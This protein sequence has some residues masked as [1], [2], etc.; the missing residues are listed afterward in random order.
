MFSFQ[1]ISIAIFLILIS[2]ILLIGV[3]GF[4]VVHEIYLLIETSNNGLQLIADVR[5][6]QANTYSLLITE[7]LD[8]GY[9]LWGECVQKYQQNLDRF[10]NS[11]RLQ[12]LLQD[13]SILINYKAFQILSR[14]ALESITNIEKEYREIRKQLPYGFG[15]LFLEQNPSLQTKIND[16]ALLCRETG[17]YFSSSYENT[18]SP[19]TASLSMES[20]KLQFQLLVI[21]LGVSFFIVSVSV[22]LSIFL[23]KEQS[24]RKAEIHE[25]EAEINKLESL[26]IFAGGIAHDFNN[27]LTGVVINLGLVKTRLDDHSE[28]SEMVSEAQD[29]ALKAAKVSSQFLTFTKGD[30]LVLEVKNISGLITYTTGFVLRGTNIKCVHEIAGDLW[31]A[32]IDENKICEVLTNI[33]LNSVQAMPDGGIIYVKAENETVKRNNKA[34]VRPG[35][36]IHLSVKDAGKGIPDHLK[37]KVF[38]P[39]FTTKSAGSGLGLAVSYSIVK[40]HSGS[41]YFETLEGRGTVFHIYLKAT[42][43]EVVETKE[44]PA[45]VVRKGTGRVLI[46][47]DVEAIR[48]SGARLLESLGYAAETAVDGQQAIDLYKQAMEDQNPFAVVILDVTVP[49]GMGGKEAMQELLHIDPGV[50]AIVSSGYSEDPV[51]AY[52]GEYGFKGVLRKAYT[53]ED[54]KEVLERVIYPEK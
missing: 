27:I 23:Q 45:A 4:W 29:A 52:F 32:E 15:G 25:M 13:E 22:L 40:K 9:I 16:F 34:R 43:K 36:F 3:L 6:V 11:E 46:M 28:L 7:N 17:N 14:R 39:F 2:S 50:K 42:D 54:M 47:D 38:D 18:I 51:M 37:K 8:V 35:K 48:K 20:E 30:A 10:N 1:H 44:L 21:Y 19:L 41:I 12:V 24:R 26:G 33:L 31:N 5:K 49:G 53:L